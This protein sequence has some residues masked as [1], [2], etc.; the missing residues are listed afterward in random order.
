M[1]CLFD[2]INCNF[3]KLFSASDHSIDETM[4]PYFGDMEPN[5]SHAASQFVLASSCGALLQLTDTHLT[6]NH[7]VELT[8]SCQS[9][10]LAKVLMQRW[11]SQKK[12]V[13]RVVSLLPLTTFL[14]VFL[15]MISFHN[16]ASK[17]WLLLVKIV[18]KMQQFHQNK[19]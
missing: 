9:Q 18:W 8:L 17:V 10:A 6:L 13:C 11:V 12:V 16:V 1:P 5:S 4:I 3:K 2:I 14:P 7:T 19:Q 15:F